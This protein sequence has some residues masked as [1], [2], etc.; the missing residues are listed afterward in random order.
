MRRGLL[1]ALA[2]LVVT[3]FEFQVYPGHSYLQGETQLL[4]PMLERLDTPGFLSRDLVASNPTF[5]YT[6]YDEI[7]QLLHAEA[8]LTFERAL[9]L[10]QIFF[11][12]VALLGLFLCARALKV[13]WYA[14]VFLSA[15]VSAVTYLAGPGFFVTSPEATPAAFSLSLVF[16]GTGLLLNRAALLG[17]VASGLALLYDPVMSAPLWVL[18]AVMS[19]SNASL[20]KYLRPAWPSLIIFGL[21]LANLVQ[22]QSGLGGEQDL[23][24]RLSAAAVQL[25]RLRTPSTW[26]TE[27]IWPSF[28]NYAFLGVA[29]IWA[30]SRIWTRLELLTRWIFLG[31]GFTGL[32][33]VAAAAMLLEARFRMALEMPPARGLA[34]TV[35]MALL[36]CGAAATVA[37]EQQRW[38]ECGAWSLLILAA[39]LNAQVLDLVHLKLSPRFGRAPQAEMRALGNWAETNTWGSSL[40]QFPDLAKDNAPGEFRAL[41]RR[42]LW[43]DWESGVIADYSEAAGQEW[44]VRW[45]ATMARPY[46]EERLQKMLN[47]P[48][49]Y[50]VLRR[51]DALAGV[52]PAYSNSLY[53]VYD[54]Q[55]VRQ[56][57]GSIGF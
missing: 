25:T 24:A 14:A 35:V 16:L 40:F 41:S 32:V 54:A 19:L 4:V 47:L 29:G 53:V 26:V 9:L 36:L 52:R 5:A 42:S 55:D 23:S 1:I 11:R 15:V 43:A 8:H 49:D 56:A 21:L 39:L 44:W 38:R 30:A 6:I 2:L 22:L 34:L 37:A 33:S 46:S 57:R 7:T 48:I 13:R 20:R 28:W 45:Q 3:W 17:G 27:W 12:F 51:R 10:Q 50:Y 18:V 31:L